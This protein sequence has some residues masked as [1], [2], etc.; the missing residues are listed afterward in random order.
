MPVVVHNSLESG[1]FKVAVHGGP[2]NREGFWWR[3]CVSSFSSKVQTRTQRD[4]LA[5]TATEKQ[6][7]YK[8]LSCLSDELAFAYSPEKSGMQVLWT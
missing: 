1:L 8:A 5:G 3:A 2:V 4:P 6:L 7:E